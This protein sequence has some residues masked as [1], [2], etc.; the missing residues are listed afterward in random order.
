LFRDRCNQ[1]NVHM[2]SS[3]PVILIVDD[4]PDA[5]FLTKRMLTQAG[6]QNPVVTAQSGEEAIDYLQN[7]HASGDAVPALLFLDVRMPVA[8][9]FKVLHQ[10]RN[11]QR[12]RTIK[13]IILT[14]SDDPKDQQRATDFGADAYLVKYPRPAVVAELVQTLLKPTDSTVEQPAKG[15]QNRTPHA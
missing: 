13:V 9:G 1:S 2:G 4:D 5:L 7:A 6:I 11:D 10:I 14:S 3:V 8:D 12:L 15:Q